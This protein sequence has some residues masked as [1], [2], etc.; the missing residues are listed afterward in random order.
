MNVGQSS[1]KR[2]NSVTIINESTM[3]DDNGQR[4]SI[5]EAARLASNYLLQTWLIIDRILPQEL[6]TIRDGLKRRRTRSSQGIGLTTNFMIFL[7]TAGVLH[8]YGSLTM[9]E[10]SRATLIP[11]STATRMID[12]MVDNG[13]V[14]RFRDGKD[15]R[16]VHIRL[17]DSGLELFLAATAQLREFAAKLVEQLPAVQ[18]TAVILV[19]KDLAITS[20]L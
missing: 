17:T 6:W 5:D 4:I 7:C 19:L 2:V 16:V 10:L 3:P 13:Y 9:G 8:R 20:V 1:P 15:G 18:R 12:R 14:D 11:R